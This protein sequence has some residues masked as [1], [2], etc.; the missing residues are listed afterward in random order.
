MLTQTQLRRAFDYEDGWL[1]DQLTGERIGVVK[2]RYLYVT[3]NYKT[4]L[5]HRL[6][7]IWHYGNCP[8]R[9]DHIDGNGFNNRIENLRECNQSQN[10]GNASWGPMRGIEKHGRKYRVRISAEYGKI[11][12]GS[13]ETLEAAIVAR[14]EGYRDYFGEFFG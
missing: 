9:I 5:V 2:A 14:D 11:E 6:I 10:S 12:L 7:W 8:D 1:I 4:Y 3:I 13:Y